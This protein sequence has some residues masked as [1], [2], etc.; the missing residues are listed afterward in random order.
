MPTFRPF[1]TKA[2]DEA[3][4]DGRQFFVVVFVFAHALT[5]RARDIGVSVSARV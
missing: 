4:L 2:P 1:A 5:L 3:V